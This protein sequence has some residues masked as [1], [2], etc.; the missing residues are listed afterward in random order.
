MS[1]EISWFIEDEQSAHTKS[2]Y[3]KSALTKA[4]PGL[5]PRCV[6]LILERV[7]W[8]LSTYFKTLS[9][10]QSPSSHTYDGS[11]DYSYHYPDTSDTSAEGESVLLFEPNLCI[12]QVPT[13]E[14][15]EYSVREVYI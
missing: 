6:E 3:T 1:M 15:T 13:G 10:V 9:T 12:E 5:S 2:T 8:K 11:Y 4:G 14:G 7:T